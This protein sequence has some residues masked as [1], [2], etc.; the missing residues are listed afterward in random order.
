[1]VF[2]KSTQVAYGNK[3]PLHLNVRFS[4]KA[5]I[6]SGKWKGAIILKADIVIFVANVRISPKSDIC[7]SVMLHQRMEKAELL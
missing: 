3:I 4:P 1:M 2:A 6:S 7:G 5:D